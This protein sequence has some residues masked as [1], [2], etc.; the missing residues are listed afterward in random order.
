MSKLVTGKNLFITTRL[1]LTGWYLLIITSISILFSVAIYYILSN[2]INNDYMRVSRRYEEGR[3]LLPEELRPP[4]ID[5]NVF[6]ATKDQIKLSLLYINL[7]ILLGSATASYFLAGRTLEPI[8]LMVDEQ[9]RFVADAS[10][11]LRTP[12]TALRTTIE[13]TL[14]DKNLN[15]EEAKKIMGSNLQDV[16]D[17]QTLSNS[18][19]LLAQ[20]GNSQNE[21]VIQELSLKNLGEASVS[22]LAVLAKDK[23]VEIHSDIKDATFKG[24]NDKLTRLLIILLENAIKYSPQNSQVDLVAFKDQTGVHL[25][26]KDDGVGIAKDDQPHIFDRFYRA[27]KS[28]SQTSGHGL[29]LA[30]AKKIID[31]H[32]GSIGVTSKP[33]A[34]SSF[35]VWLPL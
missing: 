2:Q 7:I 18:L 31:L 8:S 12:L 21:L 17:L 23:N 34:G 3:L 6:D 10:H 16:D 33:D 14:R 22:K 20:T 25:I 32:N 4:T 5:P 19:L 26:V 29:G 9:N 24:D 13:V 28:R 35:N 1:K 15:L 27:D 30:I 11:E